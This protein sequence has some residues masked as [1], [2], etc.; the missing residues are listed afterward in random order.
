MKLLVLATLGALFTLSRALDI[1][2]WNGI[3][4]CNKTNEINKQKFR[5]VISDKDET[6]GNTCCTLQSELYN[7][8]SDKKKLTYRCEDP[9]G[10]LQ[11]TM[12][13]DTLCDNDRLAQAAIWLASL[14]LVFILYSLTGFWYD[15]KEGCCY[16][17]FGKKDAARNCCAAFS[18]VF[19]IIGLSLACIVVHY[20]NENKK[21]RGDYDY[22]SSAGIAAIV[23]SVITLCYALRRLYTATQNKAT[24]N[25]IPIAD[26]LEEVHRVRETEVIPEARGEMDPQVPATPAL[27]FFRRSM[28]FQVV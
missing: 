1:P 16:E 25:K 4:E 14:S 28:R 18:S 7:S 23:L 8:W 22:Q 3:T 27:R 10:N 11:C 26:H 20:M 5:S 12:D 6:Y 15:G 19:A 9:N 13:E 24:Q 2:E 17:G 21:E